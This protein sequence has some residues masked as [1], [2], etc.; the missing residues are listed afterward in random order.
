MLNDHT[1][2]LQR[3]GPLLRKQTQAAWSQLQE[4]RLLRKPPGRFPSGLSRRRQGAL[5]KGWIR[6]LRLA[7]PLPSAPSQVLPSISYDL[8]ATSYNIATHDPEMLLP[9]RNRNQDVG[10]H[11]L[12]EALFKVNWS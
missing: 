4:S 2:S 10:L 1:M 11:V 8:M 9:K 12:L 3:L 5:Q 7:W 6:R